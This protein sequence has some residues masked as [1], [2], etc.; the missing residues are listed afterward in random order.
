MKLNLA[1]GDRPLPG[2]T[3][4]DLYGSA[5]IQ[6]DFLT[7]LGFEDGCA[8]E[9][10][11]D[12]GLEHIPRDLVPQALA[13][14]R[15]VLKPGGLIVV[16]VPNLPE[17]LRNW[18]RR[19]DDCDPQVWGWWTETIFGRQTQPGEIHFWGFDEHVLAAYLAAAGFVDVKV[20]HIESHDQPSLLAKGHKPVVEDG[21]QPSGPPAPSGQISTVASM[22]GSDLLSQVGTALHDKDEVIAGLQRSLAET[23]QYLETVIRDKDQYLETV[24]RDKD[25]HLETVIRDKDRYLETVIRD[26]DEVIAGLEQSIVSKD[27]E[28]GRLRHLLPMRAYLGVKRLLARP[29][30]GG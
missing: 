22:F 20:T 23:N 25:Q 5:D 12:H 4:V 24:I 14:W 18:L 17:V 10:R 2:Y 28:I 29:E 13:A 9:V 26:K 15:R 30:E 21:R 19:Y 27:Q 1:S 16:D 6:D 8:D 11:C 7:L 3:N